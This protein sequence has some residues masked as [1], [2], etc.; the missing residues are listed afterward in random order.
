V[1]FYALIS[2]LSGVSTRSASARGT[3]TWGAV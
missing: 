3:F 2:G 1:A